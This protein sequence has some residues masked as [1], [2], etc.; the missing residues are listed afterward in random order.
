M[1]TARFLQKWVSRAPTSKESSFSEEHFGEQQLEEKGSPTGKT[2]RFFL[3]D[4]KKGL[5][6]FGEA[7]FLF[8]KSQLAQ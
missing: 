4:E 1:N 5:P 7:P 3:L 2:S 8:F 6:I